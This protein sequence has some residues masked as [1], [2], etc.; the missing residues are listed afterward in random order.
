[1]KKEY[2]NGKRFQKMEILSSSTPE[3]S[4]DRSDKVLAECYKFCGLHGITF[5][6]NL[7]Q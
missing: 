3:I 5:C 6:Q 1:M 7:E 2:S 4:Q